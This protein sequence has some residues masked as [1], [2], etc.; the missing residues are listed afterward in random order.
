M[1]LLY[2][3]NIFNYIPLLT[4]SHSFLS[5]LLSS[6][7]HAFLTTIFISFHVKKSCFLFYKYCIIYF[8]EYDLP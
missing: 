4:A 7:R 6:T 1:T 5:P 2:A 3:I 8:N